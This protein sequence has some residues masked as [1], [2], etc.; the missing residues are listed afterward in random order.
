MTRLQA[1]YGIDAPAVIR[2]LTIA[3]VGTL[4]VGVAVIVGWIPQI[5]TIGVARIAVL[6]SVIPAGVSLSAAAAWMYFGSKYGKIAE[7]EK[8][9]KYIAWTGRERVL[10]GRA[11]RRSPGGSAR[12]GT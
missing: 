2:N 10:V 3:G 8:L 11:I 4:L 1:D 7:R 12:A 9:L 6:P 5:V